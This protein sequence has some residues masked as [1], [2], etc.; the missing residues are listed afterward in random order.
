MLISS[1]I[2]AAGYS[3]RMGSDKALLKIKGQS[4]LD[5]IIQKI[6]PFSQNIIIVT[7]SNHQLIQ[8]LPFVHSVQIVHNPH[9]ERGMFSSLQ[10]AVNSTISTSHALIHL[11]DQPFIQPETYKILISALDDQHLVFMPN[12]AAQ[13]RSGHPIII[14]PQVIDLIK[15]A[16]IDDNLRNI[17]R[18]IPPAMIKR[19]P[20]TD[21]NV[22]DNINDPT[23]LKEKLDQ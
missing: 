3:S 10:A 20:V 4:V 7:G 12:I 8:A 22:L 21:L 14:A 19:I 18:N 2:L 1:I 23:Q 15:N 13:K 16:P 9:P 17:I 11:I 5:I 6:L